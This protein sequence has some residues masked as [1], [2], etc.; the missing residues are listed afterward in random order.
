MHP[1]WQKSFI[2]D[3][4]K[5]IQEI[6]NNAK[7]KFSNITILLSSNSPFL[8]SDLPSTNIHLLNGNLESKTFGQNIYTILKDKFFMSEGVIGNF[9]VEKINKAFELLQDVK[10][11][12]LKDDEQKYIDYIKEILGDII[13]KEMLERRME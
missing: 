6:N 5:F 3:L 11:Q 7:N 10:H 12:D 13:I 2:Y 9:A 1:E 8:M 4:I